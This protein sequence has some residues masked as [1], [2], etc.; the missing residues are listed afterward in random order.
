[1]AGVS[2][3][4]LMSVDAALLHQLAPPLLRDED[5]RLDAATCLARRLQSQV[6]ARAEATAIVKLMCAHCASDG[7]LLELF[8]ELLAS[9]EHK[10]PIIHSIAL[11]AVDA[12]EHQVQAVLDAY[13]ELLE[14][15]RSFLVPI[16]GSISELQLTPAQ[17]ESFLSLIEGSLAV[18][19]DTDVPT[20]V[21]ALLQLATASNAVKIM[22]SIRAEAAHVAI[23]IATLLAS[24]LVAATRARPP[25]ARAYI[26]ELSRTAPLSSMDVLAVAGLL[27][28]PCMRRAAAGALFAAICLHPPAIDTLRDTLSSHVGND[29]ASIHLV[30]VTLQQSLGPPPALGGGHRG[31]AAPWQQLEPHLLLAT[32]VAI[33][34]ALI[35][36][37]APLRKQVIKALLTACATQAIGGATSARPDAA[38]LCPGTNLSKG[39][40]GGGFGA[41]ARD[42]A[43]MADCALIA[44]G[45]LLKVAETDA[46]S[47]HESADQLCQFFGQHAA[48]CD[49]RVMHLISATIS[50]VTAHELGRARS[51]VRTR[52]GGSSSAQ[53]P[54]VPVDND[55]FDGMDKLG[56]YS[57]VVLL[58]QKLLV[59]IRPEQL[60]SALI[61]AGFILFIIFFL[62][63]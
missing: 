27:Q 35:R 4:L 1:M 10:D 16:V 61:L 6:D 17:R 15:D 11:A 30:Y 52:G 59:S 62:S 12:A 42:G 22:R 55:D 28:V 53:G 23:P 50:C 24:P 7:F 45:T 58:I 25:C 48:V 3:D 19:D 43:E 2:E 54:R 57:G 63:S 46:A 9:V 47:L 32:S 20:M 21:S 5:T 33:S 29:A 18:V 14:Q 38:L 39:R 37:H 8:L 40:G 34:G 41:G 26:A 49:S 60:K 51:A 36:H 44:A 31:P 56:A 13:R